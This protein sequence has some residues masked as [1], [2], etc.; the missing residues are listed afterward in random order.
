MKT[1]I[2]PPVVVAIFAGAMWLLARYVE[3][4]RF[5]FTGQIGL[6]AA[7]LAV[8]LALM[9]AAVLS[10]V[11]A[12]TTVNP[13]RPARASTLVTSGVFAWSRNP[14]YLGDLLLLAACALWFGQIA[15]FALLPMFVLYLNRFQIEPEEDALTR[16]FGDDY[17]QY[18]ARVRRWL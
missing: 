18:Q 14:I 13:M 10:F 15:G 12:R 11:R 7:L 16:L 1:L 8:A 9:F 17:R 4:G 3:P 2:P 5:S 6:A